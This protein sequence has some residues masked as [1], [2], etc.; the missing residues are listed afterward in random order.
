MKTSLR[1]TGGRAGVGRGGV[2]FR[3]GP[4]DSVSKSAKGSLGVKGEVAG[5]SRGEAQG[6]QGSQCSGAGSRPPGK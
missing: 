1:V 4:C 6:H 2:G 5:M 3:K